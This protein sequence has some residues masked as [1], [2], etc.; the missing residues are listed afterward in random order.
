MSASFFAQSRAL[1]YKAGR[2]HTKSTELSLHA[3]R[4]LVPLALLAVVYFTKTH[5][6]PY[7]KTIAE[8][9]QRAGLA[10]DK[11]QA[12]A[13]V[14]GAFRTCIDYTLAISSLITA[15]LSMP[16]STSERVGDRVSGMRFLM[17]SNGLSNAAYWISSALETFLVTA[18]DLVVLLLGGYYLQIRMVSDTNVVLSLS[19]IF[20]LANAIVA[21]SF[22]LGQLLNSKRQAQ[23]LTLL[24]F[25]VVFFLAPLLCFYDDAVQQSTMMRGKSADKVN[26]ED[27][28]KLLASFWA[29]RSKYS[30]YLLM[31][32]PFTAF[33]IFHRLASACAADKCLDV[34]D[35]TRALYKQTSYDHGTDVLLLSLLVLAEIAL[36]WALTLILDLSSRSHNFAD[37]DKQ[38]PTV[39]GHRLLAKVDGL[40]RT[41][42]S[43]VA[44]DGVSF[45]VEEGACVG[46]LGPNGA[47]KSTICKILTRQLPSTGG[48]VHTYARTPQFQKGGG[49]SVNDFMGVCP[50]ATV[51]FEN[52]T[53]LDHLHFFAKLR[54]AD[55][56]AA[57]DELC[58]QFMSMVGLADKATSTPSVLSGGTQR[59]LSV[60]LSLIASP[61]CIVLDEP[62]T[63]IDAQSRQQIWQFVRSCLQTGCGALVTTHMLEEAEALCTKLVVVNQGR[64]AES[65]TTLDLKERYGT[66]YSLHVDF[67]P[68]DKDGVLAFL[69][70]LL[71]SEFH[72]PTSTSITGQMVF[73]AGKGGKAVG[74]LF[75][76]LDEHAADHKITHWGIS[77]ATLAGAYERILAES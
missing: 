35:V 30:R 20:L 68:G 60:C 36:C 63:G 64:V 45:A 11:K 19:A 72:E 42:G 61:G 5:A 69:R 14:K 9:V 3:V 34:L 67:P 29:Y 50:Q 73:Q 24:L 6:Y 21:V 39:D 47:G 27:G 53:V 1:L 46:L 10:P 62:T 58:A 41:F 2:Q 44:L 76:E 43:F 52:L 70:T 74:N 49:T 8:S 15:L 31:F 37:P 18:L 25:L 38:Q 32:P 28:M 26:S 65:G 57:E 4:L 71:P 48:A 22:L 23:M 54:G 40:Q 33:N 16:A 75:C 12:L 17:R 13:L 55:G 7:R 66:G 56:G 77:Q 59:K 51:L